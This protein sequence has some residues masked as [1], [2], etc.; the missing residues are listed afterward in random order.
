MLV[1]GGTELNPGPQM[2][3]KIERLL[4]HM[5]AQ[6]EEGKKIRELREKNKTSM[7]KLQSRIN[8][9]GAKIDQLSR[10]GKTMKEEQERIKHLVNVR[11]VKRERIERELNF[12]A[13]WRRKN[14]LLIFGID[15][16]PHESYIDT[17]K[18]TEEFLKTKI[19]VDVMNLH[20]N[21]VMRIGRR[22]YS[23][24]ILVRFTSYSKIIEVLKGTRNLAGTN[25]RIK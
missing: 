25:I 19:K 17:L 8:E 5:M 20:I 15:D 14:N 6:S 11:E 22:R 13:D 23:R 21:S 1:V 4:N 12:V 16:F 9:F 3:E 10:S 2:E 7:E 24:P 18:I